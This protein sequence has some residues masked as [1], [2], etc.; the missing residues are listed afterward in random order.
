VKAIKGTVLFVVERRIVVVRRIVE[1][2]EAIEDTVLFV[3]VASLRLCL[4][5]P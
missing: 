1:M 3:V 2:V 5:L 4:R